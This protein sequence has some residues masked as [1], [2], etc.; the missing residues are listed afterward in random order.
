MNSDK[1]NNK[2]SKDSSKN[3]VKLILALILLIIVGVG[4]YHYN[5]YKVTSVF[6][7]T[8]VE[9]GDEN[10]ISLEK[11]DYL[12]GSEKALA[13]VTLDTSAVDIRTVGDYEIKAYYKKNIYL[14]TVHVVDTVAP[15]ITYGEVQCKAIR[16]NYEVND[17][18][19][20]VT[21]ISGDVKT[22]FVIDGEAKDEICINNLGE[23]EVVINASDA[24]GNV[25]EVSIPVKF[26]L[27]PFFKLLSDRKVIAGTDFKL[28][29]YVAAC[30][31]EEGLITDRMTIEKNGFDINQPGNYS[32]TYSVT[33]KNG[34]SSSKTINITVGE[35]EILN[36]NVSDSDISYLDSN[37]YFSYDALEKEDFEE[38][39]ELA[40]RGAVNIS[41]TNERGRHYGSAFV[42][43]VTFSYIYF[44]TAKHCDF[45]LK[46]GVDVIFYN[47]Y[48]VSLSDTQVKLIESPNAD[49]LMFAI[50]KWV[51]DDRTL[52]MLKE[53]HYDK[54][55]YSKI[56]VGDEAFICTMNWKAGSK[57][58][59]NQTQVQAINVT[60]YAGVTK[61][62][63]KFVITKDSAIH[64]QSGSGVF[65]LKGNLL[66]VAS[67]IFSSPD[68]SQ[69]TLFTSIDYIEELERRRDELLR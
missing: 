16:Q 57:D 43:D 37:G 49:I 51:V 36:L 30:D 11:T 12:M 29:D 15:V 23:C 42:Y 6:A 31:N 17:F 67:M 50:P 65:D 21:D 13:K 10:A 14:Y 63:Y 54:D 7:E 1:N 59:I 47:D 8:T 46:D 66:G 4:I 39:L 26:D 52:L 27:A 58:I 20:D 48:Q 44:I 19:T 35:S 38:A 33:D 64:G 40:K 5:L 24:S 68:G 28:T 56:D 3:I 55:V 62:K 60:E 9:L 45:I 41:Y 34:L 69:Y 22:Y 53:C 2:I 25:S 61:A 18:I 32:V